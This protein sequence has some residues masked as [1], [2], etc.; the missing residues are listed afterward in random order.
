MRKNTV[1]N[2]KYQNKYPSKSAFIFFF[3]YKF[4]F[5]SHLL[6]LAFFLILTHSVCVLRIIYTNVYIFRTFPI[7]FYLLLIFPLY[8]SSKKKGKNIFL[9]HNFVLK[10]FIIERSFKLSAN[11]L[12]RPAVIDKQILT[13]YFFSLWKYYLLTWLELKLFG[14]VQV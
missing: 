1:W 7:F 11:W 6:S 14:S 12:V 5:L 10:Y 9:Q 13:G 3:C 4:S 2:S 8:F